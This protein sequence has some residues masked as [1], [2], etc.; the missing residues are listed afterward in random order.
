MRTQQVYPTPVTVTT[1]AVILPVSWSGVIIGALD[2]RLSGLLDV[3]SNDSEGT[4]RDELP[5]LVRKAEVRRRLCGSILCLTGGSP[6][7]TNRRL[8]ELSK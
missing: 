1:P 8:L 2:L 6:A 3:L 5:P 4:E 7:K